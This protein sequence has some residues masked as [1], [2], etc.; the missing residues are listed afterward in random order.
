M[1]A[2]VLSAGRG[3]RLLPFTLDRPKCLLRIA[4]RSVLD[5]QLDALEACGVT[6]AVV[7]TGFGAAGVVRHLAL[8][9]PGR[10][11]TRT[12][13]NPDF[14]RADNLV[15]CLAAASE[16]NEDFL[17]LNGDTLVDPAL[18]AWLCAARGV[19]AGVAVTAKPAYD[20]DDMKVASGLGWLDHIGK[21]LPTDGVSGEAIGVSIWRDEG[22]TLFAEALREVSREPGAERRWYL[23]AVERLALRGLVRTV[24]VDGLGYAEIDVPEDL[25]RA[26][27]LASQ[28]ARPSRRAAVAPSLSS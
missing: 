15:S 4:G 11:R 7:V 10:L 1:K 28:W 13:F 21:H 8:R 3:K 26:H 19:I 18:L 27:A 12:L 22:P 16:M 6:E 9:A 23:S 24:P 17:L 5:W 2:I 20:E 25:A 14:E